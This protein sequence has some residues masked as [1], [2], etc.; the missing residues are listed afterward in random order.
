MVNVLIEE[1]RESPVVKFN[2][3]VGKITIE[4][5]STLVDP[6]HFYQKLLNELG[7]YYKMPCP[8]TILEFRLSYINTASSKWLFHILKNLEKQSSARDSTCIEW[9]H[10]YDDESVQEAGEVYQSLIKI[11]FKVISED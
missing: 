9:Y 6:V 8:K 1:T 3:K 5:K 4:G 7:N 11:P 10:E 2:R